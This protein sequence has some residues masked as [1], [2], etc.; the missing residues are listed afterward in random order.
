MLA[1]PWFSCGLKSPDGLR[2]FS[3]R[4]SMIFPYQL[5]S[6]HLCSQRALLRGTDVTNHT[7]VESLQ[8]SN[9]DG[10]EGVGG[11]SMVSAAR[12]CSPY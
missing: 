11:Q 6:A 2:S 12:G 7:A 5:V 10:E 3:R 1:T 9:V 8:S 4:G